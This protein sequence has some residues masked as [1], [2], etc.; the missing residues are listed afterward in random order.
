M[1]LTR[2]FTDRNLVLLEKAIRSNDLFK[3]GHHILL[4]E[5][6]DVKSLKDFSTLVS[7][8]IGEIYNDPELGTIFNQM[9]ELLTGNE[10]CTNWQ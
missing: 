7:V 2:S 8:Q 3:A 9:K 10:Q 4:R 1:I 6:G 5:G